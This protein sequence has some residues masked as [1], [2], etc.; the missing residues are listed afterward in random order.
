MV[1][2]LP[3]EGRLCDTPLW[4]PDGRLWDMLLPLLWLEALPLGLEWLLL[5]EP[6]ERPEEWE[7][8]WL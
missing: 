7:P 1:P 2:W 5:I 6:P 3:P 4:P 8:P